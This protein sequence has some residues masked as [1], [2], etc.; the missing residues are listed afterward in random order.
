[1]KPETAPDSAAQAA[2]DLFGSIAS[3]RGFIKITGGSLIAGAGLLASPSLLARAASPNA[4]AVAAILSVARTAEQLAVTF[5][6][7]GLKH[8]DFGDG[9]GD[10]SDDENGDEQDHG[11]GESRPDAEDRRDLTAF[12]LEE[13]IHLN[14]FA[15]NGGSSLADTFSFP[16]GA[17]TFT[18]LTTFIATQQLLEGAFDS[19]FI[20]AVK[21]FCDL[22]HADLAQIACQIA[23]IEEGHRVLGRDILGDHRA[24]PHEEWAFAPLL[25]NK[26]ADAPGIL[27]AAGF[28]SPVPGNSYEYSAIDFGAPDFAPTYARITNRTPAEKTKPDTFGVY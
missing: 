24:E 18:D 9:D 14:F 6:T 8:L 12:A 15:A 13:Q 11:E 17:E 25:L 21:E 26:V 3:R 23:M 2:E 20:A 1:M 27:A 10:E 5:Y 19:A 22:G 16:K 4:D 28:L 7:N